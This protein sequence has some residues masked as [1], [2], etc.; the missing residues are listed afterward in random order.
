MLAATIMTG[1]R[2]FL[3]LLCF[4]CKDFL[5]D[6][7]SSSFYPTLLKPEGGAGPQLID[8]CQQELLAVKR[9]QEEKES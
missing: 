9:T 4:S 5:H 1:F 7:G 2:L 3:L 6:D 8:K